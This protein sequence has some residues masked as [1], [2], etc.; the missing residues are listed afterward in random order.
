MTT[1]DKPVCYQ[2]RC[3]DARM[4]GVWGSHDTAESRDA[5]AESWDARGVKYE[6]RDLYASPHPAAPQVPEGWVLVPLDPTPEMMR[7]AQDN[8]EYRVSG[9]G[10]YRTYR[11]MLNATPPAPEQPRCATCDGRGEI[12]GHVGQTPESF[13]FVTEPCPECSTPEQPKPAGDAEIRHALQQKQQACFAYADDL[14]NLAVKA[15]AEKKVAA[16]IS[17]SLINSIISLA[18]KGYFIAKEARLSAKPAGDVG[19]LAASVIEEM[20]HLPWQEVEP[21]AREIA[22]RLAAQPAQGEVSE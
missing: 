22:R 6:T 19:A 3:L 16:S 12:G 4:P 21:V 1:N 13:D 15:G 11:A 14:Y 2:I 9:D 5:L 8:P 17:H 10:A 20:L 18:S 7:A